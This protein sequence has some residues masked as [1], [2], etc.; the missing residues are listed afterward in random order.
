[1]IRDY[2]EAGED[3]CNCK[4]L[5]LLAFPAQPAATTLSMYFFERRRA[6]RLEV[7]FFRIPPPRT[8]R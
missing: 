6:R 2:H 8:N 1:M 5:I 7:Y 4:Q 3:H